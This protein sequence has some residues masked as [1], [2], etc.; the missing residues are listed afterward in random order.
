VYLLCAR[1]MN[2]ILVFMTT[3]QNGCQEPLGGEEP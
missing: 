3:W 1:H 2:L